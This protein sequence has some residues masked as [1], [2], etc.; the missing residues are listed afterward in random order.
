MQR[1]TLVIAATIALVACQDTSAPPPPVAAIRITPDSTLIYVHGA[2]QLAAAT[3]DASGHTLSGHPITWSSADTTIAT[4]DSTGLV[5]GVRVGP[6]YVRA[7]AEGHQAFARIDAELAIAQLAVSPKH[8]VLAVSD[9]F[10]MSGVPLD[11]SGSPIGGRVVS[12]TSTDPSIAS[13]TFLGRVIGHAL[14]TVRVTGSAEGHTDTSHVIVG[15]PVD[16]L[17]VSPRSAVLHPGDSLHIRDTLFG[18]DNQPPTDSTLTWTSSDS[19]VASISSAGMLRTH[20]LGA[21]VITA[22]SGAARATI[23]V[24]VRVRTA[25]VT[26]TP[27]DTSVLVGDLASFVTISRDSQGDTL[28]QWQDLCVNGCRLLYPVAMTSLD[29]TVATFVTCCTVRARSGGVDT[30]TAFSD[31]IT[32]RAVLHVGFLGFTSVAVGYAGACGLAVD[33]VAYCWSAAHPTHPRATLPLTALSGDGACGL[34]VTGAAY[35]LGNSAIAVGQGHTYTSLTVG[36]TFA[37]GL[38]VSGSAWCWN[39]GYAGQL[40]NGDTVSSTTPVAVSGGHT[41]AVLSAGSDHACGIASDSTAYCWG[42]NG[43]GML[44]A[45]D[46]SV[47][48][49]ATPVL[50]VGGLSFKAIS[51]GVGYSCGVTIAGDAY[52]WGGNAGGDLG[53]GD[54]VNSAVPR[55]VIDGHKFTRI[56]A[57]FH[58]T[59]A[60]TTTG[61]AYCWGGDGY[62]GTGSFGPTASPV[63]VSGGLTFLSIGVTSSGYVYGTCGLTTAG[64]YCWGNG[65]TGVD[66]LSLTLAPV[67]VQGQQ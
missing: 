58:H 53:T 41:F 65:L 8:F 37:C 64:V 24:S 12:W 10:Q 51:A 25:T 22:A 19:T 13:V 39:S 45:G 32:A 60:V 62:L 26:T 52:C 57:G 66:G 46:T 9:T 18:R 44:G 16:S 54:S 3:Y 5:R 11:S 28:T 23:Q 14:G 4:V 30:I 31:G 2:T 34:S 7:A 36:G 47:H 27:S 15:V 50:V 61:D 1:R 48:I 59:C 63:L 33:S 43:G 38:D 29:T 35:C 40:G 20:S 6:V 49:S 42:S 56:S 55:L 67:K 17:H 21:A